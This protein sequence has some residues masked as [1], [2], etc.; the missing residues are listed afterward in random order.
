MTLNEIIEFLERKSCKWNSRGHTQIEYDFEI[1][2]KD[3]LEYAE[4]DL[5][6][7]YS[8]KLINSLSNAKRA[9]DC[10]VDI[11]LIAFGFYPISKKK[12]WSFPNKIK[13]IKELGIIAPRVLLKINKTRNLMEHHFLRPTNEQVEDFVDIVSLFIS[14]TD[15]IIND[16]PSDMQIEDELNEDFWLDFDYDYK[17]QEIKIESINKNSENVNWNITISENEYLEILKQIIRIAYNY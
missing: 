11:L 8:H 2:P 5:S 12:K 3:F 6:N 13:I 14:S 4:K 17:K 15:K 1:K 7:E 16:F 9:L 10:Q